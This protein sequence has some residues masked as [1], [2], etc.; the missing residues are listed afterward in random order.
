MS[1]TRAASAESPTLQHP[2]LPDAAFGP[3]ATPLRRKT[4]V[5]SWPASASS[6][7]ATE[8]STPPLMATTTRMARGSIHPRS[9]AREDLVQD[10][11]DSGPAEAL[12]FGRSPADLASAAFVR[13]RR[14]IRP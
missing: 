4:P 8:L 10:E 2:C 9:A 13:P 3:A 6:A 1:A 14:R 7:A 12:F 5:T 11:P